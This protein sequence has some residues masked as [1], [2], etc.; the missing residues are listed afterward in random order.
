MKQFRITQQFG[1]A[2]RFSFAEAREY[3]EDYRQSEDRDRREIAMALEDLI[4]S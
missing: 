1:P 3:I 4:E 2:L